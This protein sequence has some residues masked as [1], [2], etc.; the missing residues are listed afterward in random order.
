MKPDSGVILVNVLVVLAIGSAITVLMFTS[1]DSL[2]ERTAR[3]AAAAQAEAL[4]LGAETSVVIALKRDMIEAPETD[5]F[6]EVWAATAQQDVALSTGRFSVVIEDAQSRF[7]LNTLASGGIGTT[8]IFVRLT[9]DIGLADDVATTIM[10][11]LTARGPVR[12]LSEIT[13]L[14]ETSQTLLRPHVTALPVPGPINLNT[15]SAVV[16][17]AVLGNAPAARQLVKT[18][19]RTGFLRQGD[20]TDVG[21]LATN[22]AGFQSQVFDVTSVAEVDGVTFTLRSRVL[23]QT[24]VGTQDV[25][26]IRRIIGAARD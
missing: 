23:R 20:L 24:G 12:S 21:V 9:R 10:Q 8:Q 14:D 19:E 3:A 7:N 26:V 5:H 2:L 18:R 17:G 15:A 25:T 13:G 11:Q 22:G 16:M 4:V 1:Q 6:Q